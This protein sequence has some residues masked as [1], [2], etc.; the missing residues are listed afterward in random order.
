MKT[1]Y[2]TPDAVVIDF[3]ASEQIAVVNDPNEN[4]GPKPEPGVGSRDF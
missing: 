2:E 4:I 3:N 1:V